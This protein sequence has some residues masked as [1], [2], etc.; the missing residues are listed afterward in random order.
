MNK[1]RRKE[2]DKAIAILQEIGPKWDEVREICQ[3]EGEAEREYYDNM[4]ENLQSGE[5]GKQ[6]DEAA[7]QL[8][9]VH[10]EIDTCDLADLITKLEEARG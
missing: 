3:L 4:A 5:K 6:A 1:E 9:E 2:I 10:N 7:T 8:E